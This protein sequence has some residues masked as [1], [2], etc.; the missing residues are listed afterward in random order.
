MLLKENIKVY[1]CVHPFDMSSPLKSTST[2]EF[3]RERKKVWGLY[4][5]VGSGSAAGGYAQ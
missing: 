4:G 5:V 3:G 1:H 2:C